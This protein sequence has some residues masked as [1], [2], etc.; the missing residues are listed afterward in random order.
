MPSSTDRVTISDLTSFLAPNRRLNSS[1]GQPA[2]NVRWDLVP[3]TGASG[4][5]INIQDL[6]EILVLAP[7]MFGG[8]RAFNGPACNG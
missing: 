4:S 5:V 3:G 8:R 6:T 7:P 1:P 2:Y